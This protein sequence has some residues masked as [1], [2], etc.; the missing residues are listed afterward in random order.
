MAKIEAYWVEAQTLC[1]NVNDH[2]KDS[3]DQYQA[4][5]KKYNKAK[6]VIKDFQQRELEYIQYHHDDKKKIEDLEKDH[7]LEVQHL[8]TRVKNFATFIYFV[9]IINLL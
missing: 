3:Q 1:H 8:Q 5:E 7:F 6:K 4:L 9:S 2:L